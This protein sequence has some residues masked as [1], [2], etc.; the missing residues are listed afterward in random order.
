MAKQQNSKIMQQSH[1]FD[2]LPF[3]I[4]IGEKVSLKKYKTNYTKQIGGKEHSLETLQEDVADLAQAQELLWGTKQQSLLIIFQAMDAAGKDG[5]I[6]HVLSGVNPQGCHVHSFKAPS[7][8]E[9]LHHFLWRP[10]KY[11]P[12]R[13]D[14]TIFNRS[15]YEE[16][17]VVRVHPEFL[18]KQWLPVKIKNA[19][20]DQVWKSRFEE[21]NEFEKRNTKNG[22][23]VIK[24][25]LHLL[26][27]EQK[28]R[29]LKRLEKPEKQW[30]FSVSDMNER[31]HWDAYQKAFEDMLTH[32]NTAEAP[33]YVIPADN[34]WFMRAL[35]ADII[36]SRIESMNL[37]APRVSDER[38]MELE[39]IK[40]NLL[41]EKP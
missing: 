20:L 11:L 38:K 39:K 7:E 3:S 30:K 31:K 10:T 22:I 13:G 19:P 27:D 16:V 4:P 36:T 28:K 29:F 21:I 32:T 23:S 9:R 2:L 35:V 41:A 5:T 24:F 25:F 18:N 26:K 12:S 14:I 17:L 34:K 8:E 15:Y 6:K 40:K 1:R 37:Q 33:W